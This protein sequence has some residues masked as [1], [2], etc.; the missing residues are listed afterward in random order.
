M[1]RVVARGMDIRL[2][3][4]GVRTLARSPARGLGGEGVGDY[5]G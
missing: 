2:S 5:R 4:R 1:R 3:G